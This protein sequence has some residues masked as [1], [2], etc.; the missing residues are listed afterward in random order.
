VIKKRNQVRQAFARLDGD[1]L[2]SR[3]LHGE[4]NRRTMRVDSWSVT[5]LLF[6]SQ[7]GSSMIFRLLACG[8][9]GLVAVSSGIAADTPRP[10]IILI[11]SDDYG[12]PGV[13]SYG[14]HY[15]TPNLDALAAGGIRFEHC[16]SMPLCGPSRAV[17]LSGRY[18]F[19]NGVLSNGHGNAYRPSDSPSIAKTLHDAGY[20]TAVA[21]KWRQLQYFET[22][23]D[24]IAWGFDEFMIWGMGAKGERYWE[25]D[26]NHN[27]KPVH[28]PDGKYGPD[29]LH[30]FVMDFIKRHKAGPF[31]VY[32]P[33]PLVH[34][35]ILKTP[36]TTDAG[37]KEFYADN[38]A[39]MDKLVGKLVKE[40]DELNLRKNTLIVFTGDN[41]SVGG[42][43][44][45]TMANG[46]RVDG[47]KGSMKEGGSRVPL[48]VNWPG[49]T[50]AGKVLPD[51]VDFS[52]FYATFAEL[53]GAKLPADVKLDGRSFAP[54][55]RG[56]K[57]SPR[58]WAFVQLQNEWYA[59]S[60]TYK[61]TQGG[62]LLSMKDAPY[63]APP[64]DADS[65][66][67]KAARAKL[68]AALDELNPAGGKTSTKTPN[69]KKKGKKKAAAA[70]STTTDSKKS[71]KRAA[72]K[73]AKK[74]AAVAN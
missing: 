16:F 39:Y 63:T 60:Q 11:F 12:T 13:G 49:V 65:T 31:F 54:Q 15:S 27:G 26:Y 17:T 2:V 48:I 70:A 43:E 3:P 19:R 45:L 23:D 74:P 32:Y 46:K 8:I 62:D 21:G 67:A 30:E 33:T 36:D 6:S 56:E 57:G 52:D 73:E 40:L 1:F 50:P 4:N 68:Q 28:N 41:G 5:S 35:P 24:A 71:A 59:R 47:Q 29:L 22:K 44:R 61:L 9:A 66:D 53:A 58:E 55:L 7:E 42:E 38:V 20:A 69:A 64:A 72:R 25:P 10:N 34:G 14:G 37:K 51:L 18:P